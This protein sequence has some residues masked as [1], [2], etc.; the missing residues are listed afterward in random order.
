MLRAELFVVLDILSSYWL[1]DSRGCQRKLN[2]TRSRM[3]FDCIKSLLLVYKL[4]F[5]F[6]I[7]CLPGK[8]EFNWEILEAEWCRTLES[9]V[10]AVSANV[11]TFLSHQSDSIVKTS[12][13]LRHIGSGGAGVWRG[14]AMSLHIQIFPAGYKLFFRIQEF[15]S[16]KVL[17]F[18]NSYKTPTL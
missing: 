14:T 10:G 9:Q 3:S 16:Q 17:V 1:T 13:E 8:Q 2:L 5:F 7:N 12:C 15:S 6:N 18:W 11:T 4:L